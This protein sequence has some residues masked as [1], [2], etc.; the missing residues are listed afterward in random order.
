MER[1]NDTVGEI[2][3]QVKQFHAR[4]QPFRIYHGS[5]NSTRPS[6]HTRSRIV[7]TS[8]L[9]RVLKVDAEN[10]VVITEP[11]VPMDKLIDATLPHGLVPPVV[12]EFPGITAGGGFSGTSGES[13]SFRHGFFERTVNSIEI[14]LAN[15]EI[16]KAS[17]VENVD[18]FYGAASS[19]GTLGIVTLLE[20]RLIAAKEYVSLTYSPFSSMKECMQM[21]EKAAADPTIDYLDGILYSKSRG[22]VCSG[23]LTDTSNAPLQ[24][25]TRAR[26][27]WFYRHA[28]KILK[29]CPDQPTTETIPLVDY[30]FR[31]DR[32]GFW[33]AK[34]AFQYFATPFNRITRWALDNFM[35]TRVM[36]HALHQSGFSTQYIVQDVGVPWRA[37]EQFTEYLERS[38]GHYPIWLCPLGRTGKIPQAAGTLENSGD[39]DMWLNFGVWGPGPRKTSEF[40]AANRALEQAVQR[41][42]G[43]KWL[44]AH[45]YYT[46]Q[47]FWSMYN[48]G[49]YDALREKYHATYLPNIYQKVKVDLEAEERRSRETWLGWVLA[50][51]WSIWPLSGLYGVYMALLG[52]DYLLRK[53]ITPPL[54]KSKSL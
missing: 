27:P 7:D 43:R 36:Y 48:R 54:R 4:Q 9:D 32:G 29:T 26:D 10:G 46:E 49:E 18:L 24:R 47:E 33:V 19:W 20:I 53:D 11:N 31:Y 23:S 17:A 21:F 51:F 50:T 41:L 42:G 40:V 44:Y 3:V 30:L 15:G 38:F 39:G 1:H 5:T 6:Q 37:A 2:A 35:H 52:G 22:V 12:M 13:S 16:Q 25:F 34:Y 45:T 28:E 8:T 14:V